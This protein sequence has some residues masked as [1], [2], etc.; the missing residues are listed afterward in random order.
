M[1]ASTNIFYKLGNT[2]DFKLKQP[3]QVM[4]KEAGE[5]QTEETVV[6][7][8]TGRQGLKALKRLQDVVFKAFRSTASKTTN[9]AKDEQKDV[10]VDDMLSML[11]MTGS[12]EDVFDKVM[13]ALVAFG[14]LGTSKLTERLQDEM[15]ID[16]LEG[17]Y[18]EVLRSFL[19]PRIT[20][21]MNSLSK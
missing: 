5:Y 11:E 12:S 7:A 3:L 1:N 9:E 15:A 20:Q 17:L 2:M 10:T 19:L 13:G 8:F 18:Q 14:K 16:D 4:N 21:K 6:V